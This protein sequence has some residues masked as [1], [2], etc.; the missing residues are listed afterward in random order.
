VVASGTDTLIHDN[1]FDTGFTDD[2]TLDSATNYTHEY[3]NT[4]MGG[5]G[6]PRAAVF[7][8][9]GTT[10]L[11]DRPV[12]IGALPTGWVAGTRAFVNNGTGITFGGA[13]GSTG[14]VQAPVYF[15]T[16]WKYG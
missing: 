16:A 10:N 2:Y 13:V 7:T 6:A 3:D 12:A 9:A 4:Y 1:I 8:N 15:D 14:S 11:T 5:G